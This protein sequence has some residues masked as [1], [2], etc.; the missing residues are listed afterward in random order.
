MEK[1]LEKLFG[2]T[3]G[4]DVVIAVVTLYMLPSVVAKETRDAW[5]VII[6]PAIWLVVLVS[7]ALSGRW[8]DW[9][10][11]PL[12]GSPEVRNKNHPAWATWLRRSLFPVTFLVDFLGI[13]DKVDAA[14]ETAHQA[15]QYPGIQ[16]RQAGIYQ[17]AK[18]AF[19]ATEQWDRQVKPYLEFSKAARIFVWPLLAAFV[20]VL[21]N[22]ATG[23]PPYI[24]VAAQ[25]PLGRLVNWS[26]YRWVT[27][28]SWQ[29]VSFLYLSLRLVHMRK[30]YQL[31]S[32]VTVYPFQIEKKGDRSNAKPML[33]VGTAVMPLDALEIFRR[34]LCV[35]K[36]GP[37]LKEQLRTLSDPP[38]EASQA[39]CETLRDLR[40]LVG[41]KEYCLYV[42]SSDSP[43]GLTRDEV[44]RELRAIKDVAVYPDAVGQVMVVQEA[45]LE[46]AQNVP[47]VKEFLNKPGG[48][49]NG[50]ALPG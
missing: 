26:Q 9:L 5:G 43:P 30:L 17:S 7:F 8:D 22:H 4:I 6:V 23:W 41:D 13:L 49:K 35:G 28:I 27:Y 29:G 40:K 38:L 39:K 36:A 31:A 1:I 11:D 12:Y 14:R 34:V 32:E 45:Q 10:F 42:V 48:A 15:F 20:W 21:L 25:P 3:P 44:A 33:N 24:P 2:K 50:F 37:R 46:V 18:T 19:N 16:K 47:A